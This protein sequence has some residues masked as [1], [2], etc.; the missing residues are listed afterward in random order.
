MCLTLGFNTLRGLGSWG[1]A[2]VVWAS[3]QNIPPS[4]WAIIRGKVGHQMGGNYQV[5]RRGFTRR[6]RRVQ[7]QFVAVDND[8][9]ARGATRAQLTV[10]R[11]RRPLQRTLTLVWREEIIGWTKG[12]GG[13]RAVIIMIT[14][15][16]SSCRS[17][18]MTEFLS[19]RWSVLNS[20]KPPVKMCVCFF[21]LR[22]WE[23]KSQQ[24]GLLVDGGQVSC[25]NHCL[26]VCLFVGRF[27]CQHDYT[28]N[29]WT[30]SE[31]RLGKEQTP[32]TSG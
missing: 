6:G 31:Q 16:S 27:V 13:S 9:V 7:R 2:A 3:C 18:D 24:W 1:E 14:I 5:E 8:R 22:G 30:V 20:Y 28:K 32:L 4:I 26:F 11:P 12:G 15:A 19:C 25:L 17:K 10:R 29:Y 21:C 23:V